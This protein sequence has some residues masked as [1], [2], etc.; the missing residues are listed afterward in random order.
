VNYLQTIVLKISL[1]AAMDGEIQKMIVLIRQVKKL[2]ILNTSK[3]LLF[4][5][6]EDRPLTQL[7]V[8]IDSG[9]LEKLLV[10]V[11]AIKVGQHPVVQAQIFMLIQV[12]QMIL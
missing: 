9:V 11:E 10:T 1:Q 4:P 2:V 7:I 3:F 12:V 6:I 5:V 8:T